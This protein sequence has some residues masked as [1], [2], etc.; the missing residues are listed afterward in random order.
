M[1]QVAKQTGLATQLSLVIGVRWLIFRNG[2]RSR[3]E[4]AHLAGTVL[5]GFFIGVITLGA[6]VLICIG[7][8]AITESGNWL[9]L[10]LMFWG[11]FSLWQVAPVLAAEMNPGFDGRNLLRFP[12]RFS[13][14]FLMGAAYG[15]ADPF[16]LAGIL[17][18]LAIALGVTI[19]RPELA[20]WAALAI[21]ISVI[22]NV[23][24]NRLVFAWLERF[25]AKRRVKEIVT[26]LFVML[27]V[28]MQFSGILLQ[29]RGQAMKN[30][31]KNSSGVWSVL[32]PALPGVVIEDASKD[33]L[34]G[35]LR[36]AG[37][38][39][40]YALVFGA[41]YAIRVRAQY[42]GE[43]LGESAAP[44]R[45]KTA[46]KRAPVAA[47]AIAAPAIQQEGHRSQIVSA[48][49]AGIFVKELRYFYRNTML[50]MNIFMPLVFIAF[51]SLTP[52]VP[53]RQGGPPFFARF[54]NDFA[55][56]VAVVYIV[57]LMMNFC[58][59][60][61]A[62]EGRGIERLFLAPI[63]FRDVMLG[64]NLFHG[65]LLA[66]EALMALVLVSVLGHPPRPVILLATWAALLFAGL[67]H[68]GVGNWLSLQFP[69]R[70]EFGVR[71]QRPSGLTMLISFGLFFAEVGSVAAAAALCIWLAGLWLLPVVYLVMSAIG[72]VIYR[73]ILEGTT[74]QAIAQQDT[75]LEQLS[76]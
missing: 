51:L 58:P 1:A 68:L 37:L 21:T 28:S 57:L 76:R 61:L 22:M 44:V 38:L 6:A 40:A 54:G 74:R 43:D 70:F 20:G 27:A 31:L 46:S 30:A 3:S 2:L 4:K 69:R 75:L 35:A 33:D 18:H 8:F 56:P 25:L 23:L 60:N 17:W 72:F 42:T 36:T 34:S 55:Y 24:F 52:G 11:I 16:A 7:A 64:K 9:A 63:K 67:I 41:L 26:V 32:P 71:R 62:Y 66:L 5:L 53:R 65:G 19:A 12:L 15:V 50:M 48:Q 29:R 39:S 47:P 73:L 13:A 49:V 14:F 59:N 10:S 45:E